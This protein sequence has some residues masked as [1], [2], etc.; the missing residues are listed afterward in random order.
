[1]RDTERGRQKG[2]DGEGECF[3]KELVGDMVGGAGVGKCA[4][5]D[6]MAGCA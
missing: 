2:S 1:M 5:C 3:L 6:L 4:A